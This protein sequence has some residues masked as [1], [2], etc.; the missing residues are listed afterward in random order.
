MPPDQANH[1][2]RDGDFPIVYIA[3]D[4]GLYKY[5]PDS[6]EIYLMKGIDYEAGERGLMVGYA[7]LTRKP[8]VGGI[9]EIVIMPTVATGVGSDQDRVR[10]FVPGDGWTDKIP[11]EPSRRWVDIE[12]NPLN[13]DLWC[14]WDS[15]PAPHATLHAYVSNDSGMT[16]QRIQLPVTPIGG[17]EPGVSVRRCVWSPHAESFLWMCG[18]T[19]TADVVGSGDVWYGD[20][21]AGEMNRI[22]LMGAHRYTNW[23]GIAVMEN[24][25]IHARGGW[26]SPNWFAF[27]VTPAG[28]HVSYP[29][30]PQNIAGQSL[31]NMQVLS[32]IGTE[33]IL[34]TNHGPGT[35][36]TLYKAVSYESGVLE[37]TGLVL[38]NSPDAAGAE[39]TGYIAVIQGMRYFASR[40]IALQGIREI[41]NP[42]A[43]PSILP[44]YGEGYPV[45]ALKADTQTRTAMVA[46]SKRSGGLT[47]LYV[48][49]DGVWSEMAPP[50]G[51]T[52]AGM[53]THAISA[54]VR[55]E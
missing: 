47:V 16:W 40:P 46:M 30:Y 9:L 1:A 3:G 44:S 37:S 2:I 42:F 6:G 54:I 27:S 31:D 14:A 20:P 12:V 35:V 21:F 36:G 7:A 5:F 19:N 51:A 13:P 10:H 52:Q 15:T 38:N 24:G 32:L 17:V 41:T 33:N 11:P 23:N 28:S 8:P 18:R 48:F 34:G 55:P 39:N 26:R 53:A 29:A 22:L 43:S 49:A 45:G 4:H 25:D 50:E